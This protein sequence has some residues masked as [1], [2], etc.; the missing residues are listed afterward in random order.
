VAHQ[1]AVKVIRRLKEEAREEAAGHGQRDG[2]VEKIL[3][4]L[5]AGP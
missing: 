5:T 4:E 2:G 3:G 1:E